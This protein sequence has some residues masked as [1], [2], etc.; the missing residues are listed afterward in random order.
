MQ[1]VPA[2]WSIPTSLAG[3]KAADLLLSVAAGDYMFALNIGVAFHTPEAFFGGSRDPRDTQAS[4]W[5]LGFDPR[6]LRALVGG[7][8][9][10][11]GSDP[12]REAGQP[13]VV[14]LVGYPAAGKSTFCAKHLPGH[15]R[16]NQDAL[17]TVPKCVGRA[18]GNCDPLESMRK[19]LAERDSRH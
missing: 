5:Q 19:Q 6:A 14:V 15:V 12:T 2:A 10:V 4:H 18:W 3:C 1:C 11:D 16:V 7:D 17:G 8:V 13:E 9:S